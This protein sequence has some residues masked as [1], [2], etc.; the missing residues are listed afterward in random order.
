MFKNHK[1]FFCSE[2]TLEMREIRGYRT[3]LA[4][5]VLASVV[6]IVAVI[7]AANYVS[8]DWLGFNYDKTA[9]LQNETKVLRNQIESLTERMFKLREHLDALAQ[10][11][12]ELRLM[13]DLPPIDSDVRSVGTGG[14]VDNYDFGVYTSSAGVVQTAN[15][16][17]DKLEREI[18]LQQESYKGILAKYQENRVLFT[19]IPAVR[20]MVGV[21]SMNSF[22]V[23]FHP[24]LHYYKMHEG[25]DILGEPGTPV[26]ATGE[27]TIE[28][29]G[30]RDAYGLVIE[31]DHGY[32]YKSLYA[33]LST[34]LVKEGQTVKRGQ[35]IARSGRSGLVSGPHLHYEVSYNG[36]KQNP[37]DYF[38][39][40]VNN[41]NR[42]E[43][44]GQM[45]EGDTGQ[46]AAAKLTSL[47]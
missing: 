2:D 19:R 4:L 43:V 16:L 28:F 6:I 5:L 40:D 25:V 10:N 14:A 18:K 38:L 29:V 26:Y 9:S 34:A 3:K 24:V 21:Y 42:T 27:G 37:V 36:V 13:V 41:L 11:D 44:A 35:Q 15:Q 47:D 45:L 7:V 17:I 23:R 12:K 30:R 22:G 31:I 46:E 39:D 8:G 20:P 1:V 32:G 33:H